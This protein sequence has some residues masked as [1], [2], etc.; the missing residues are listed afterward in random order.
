MN[1][2]ISNFV[3]YKPFTYLFNLLAK[4]LVT[5]S[6]I[7]C[8]L[9]NFKSTFRNF[10]GLLAIKKLPLHS[11][12]PPFICFFLWHSWFESGQSDGDNVILTRYFNKVSFWFCQDLLSSWFNSRSIDID[13]RC[14]SYRRLLVVLWVTLIYIWQD[15]CRVTTVRVSFLW[16]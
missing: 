13:A 2:E 1:Y 8:E 3:I 16:S 6:E 7:N 10:F 5:D 4:F 15:P 12:S 14:Y 9:L 11:S